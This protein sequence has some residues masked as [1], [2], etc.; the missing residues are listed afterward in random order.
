VATR[1]GSEPG[2]GFGFRPG[3]GIAL[4]PIGRRLNGRGRWRFF[5]GVWLLYLLPGFVSAWTEHTGF[6][7]GLRLVLLV[8]FCWVYVDLVAR[9]LTGSRPWLR[10]AAPALL[11]ALSLALAAL[12]GPDSLGTVVYVTVAVV[13]L[14]QFRVG[15]P[16]AAAGTLL[17]GLS[18]RIVPS[19]AGSDTWAVAGSVALGSLAAFG[20]QALIR[21]TWELRAAQQEVSRLA[22]E[23]E[24]MR[25]ARDLHDLLGHS[26]TAASVKAQLAGRL[27]GRDDTRA[28]AEIG[29][30]ERL[31]RQVLADVRA[32]V[33]G[34]REVSLA[35]ELATAREVLGAAGIAA[36]LPGAV[37]E[38]P[39][40][41][42][43]HPEHGRGGRRRARSRGAGTGQRAGRAGRAGRGGRRS[44][45][46]RT[47]AGR[48]LPAGADG[49]A[50]AR[51]HPGTARPADT[52]R[53]LRRSRRTAR[54]RTRRRRTIARVPGRR[55]IA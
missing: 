35:V 6:D 40:D 43:G 54:A 19:W 27:V 32:A 36:D 41:H 25:I 10:W 34:Y 24:R 14:Q 28:A 47:R 53:Y 50:R 29:D 26:L 21:R 1:A 45:R 17:V 55:W 33:A 9:A 8:A 39:G 18:S 12:V 51:G 23:R 52:S 11:A 42:S 48:R 15:V 38:V 13:V 30:V 3:A 44:P 4:G 2:W 7:R 37:D 5:A 49:P 20:F 31:T 22:A 16:I 46:R